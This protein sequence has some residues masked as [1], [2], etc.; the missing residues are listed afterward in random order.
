MW[1]SVDTHPTVVRGSPGVW[2]GKTRSCSDGTGR[3]LSFV[4]SFSFLVSLAVVPGCSARSRL[5]V[6]LPAPLPPPTIHRSPLRTVHPRSFRRVASPFRTVSPLASTRTEPSSLSMSLSL[7]SS[8]PPLPHRSSSPR[9]RS[10]RPWPLRDCTEASFR[11]NSGGARGTR[12]ARSFARRRCRCRRRR[13]YQMR[14][15][16][17]GW[18]RWWR[19][20]LPR[21]RR[22]PLRSCRR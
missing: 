18:P 22:G 4:R 14:P 9:C 17:S 19:S 3:L 10:R 1:L 11:T 15:C 2:W 20:I 21:R 12:G 8:R 7:P 13:W 5:R 16:P 6:D